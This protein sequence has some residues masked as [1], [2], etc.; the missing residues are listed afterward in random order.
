MSRK[1]PPHHLRQILFID[2][3][4]CL[5]CGTLMLAFA[6]PL[7][8]FT[9]I[10][11]ALLLY[12]GL[13]LFPIAAFMAVVG[14]AWARSAPALGAVITGNL[15]WCAASLW[16]MVGGVIQPT[17]FGQAFIG[18]QALVVLLL[19]VLEWRAGVR[20]GVIRRSAEAPA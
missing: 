2:A 11:T 3:L 13:A 1:Q 15:A 14:G 10:P 7:G 6:Q 16:L 9:Q 19:S 17:L 20:S 18:G 5:G 12:A 8:G 4:T